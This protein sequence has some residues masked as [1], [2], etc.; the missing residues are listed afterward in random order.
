MDRH[1]SGEA[2][3]ICSHGLRDEVSQRE[4]RR[5][6][7]CLLEA[8]AKAHNILSRGCRNAFRFG[9][10][11][12]K[13]KF[14]AVQAGAII[15]VLTLILASGG[16]AASEPRSPR[17]VTLMMHFDVDGRDYKVVREAADRFNKSQQD[18]RVEVSAI[19]IYYYNER[20]ENAGATGTLPCLIWI[21]SPYLY[22]FAWS[23]YLRPLDVFAPPELIRDLL[24]SIVEQ[25]RYQGRLYSLGQF[26]VGLGLWANRRYLRAA[27]VRI[28]TV[29]S[30]WSLAEFEQALQRLSKVKGVDHPLNMSIFMGTPN[31]FYAFAITPFLKSFGGD[32]LTHGSTVSADG[33]LNGPKSVAAMKRF[34]SWFIN[35]WAAKDPHGGD[36]F[37]GKKAA[38][39]WIGAWQYR[40]YREALGRDLVLLPLPDFGRGVKTGI[41]SWSWGMSS[42]CRE[43]VGAWRFLAYLMT[44]TEILRISEADGAI[45]ARRSVLNKSPFYQRGG[46]RRVLAE[47]LEAGY[48]VRRPQYVNYALLSL[49]LSEAVRAIASGGD[50]KQELDKATLIIDNDIA[51][52]N[53]YHSY[54]AAK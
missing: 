42:T 30:P 12:E 6:A 37:A 24:P 32:I 45:P 43:P 49:T 29:K 41:G 17:I 28:P 16:R 1:C 44:P 9:R 10:R 53:G 20:I 26:D 27:G 48:G 39:S 19:D 7:V 22:S 18:Y 23:G 40:S 52:H 54:A 3:K 15:A 36:S 21:D 51:A 4:R 50:V 11:V 47:Q 5:W 25:G 33:A 8:L 38:L 14:Y 31:E 35:G 34:Q 46:P 2:G 13:R